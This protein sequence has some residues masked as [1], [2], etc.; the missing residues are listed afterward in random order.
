M[1]LVAVADAGSEAEAVM[2]VARLREAGIPAMSK[3][4]GAR[5]LPHFGSGASQTVFVDGKHEADARRTLEDPGFTDDELAAL[6]EEAGREQGG[7]P[8]V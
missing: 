2:L 5:G 8:T 4:T 3:G 6:A 1:A 7:P